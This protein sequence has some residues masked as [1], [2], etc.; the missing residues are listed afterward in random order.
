MPINIPADLPARVAL[1]RENIF[2][3]SDDKAVCQ[4]IRPMRLAIVNLMPTKLTTEIQLLRLLGNTPLQID[5]ILLRAENHVSRHT[6]HEHLDKFYTTFSQV[7]D[8]KFDGMIIT[9]APVELLPFEE[10]DYW[11]EL[12]T[13]MDY[14]AENVFSTMYICWGAQAGLY[15]RYGIPKYPLAE[16]KFGVFDHTLLQ[17]GKTLFRGFDDVFRVPHSRHTEV[18]REDIENVPALELLATSE[19][20][21]VGVVQAHGTGEIFVTGHFEYEADT[22]SQEYFRDKNKNLPIK[23]PA[24]YFPGD[25]PALP[26][27]NI[28]RSHAHLFFSNW[29]NYHVYQETPYDLGAIKGVRHG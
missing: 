18:R 11:E 4:D 26:P 7:K 10:V 8:R 12:T 20:A 22:L 13:I 16:K 15:H 5:I 17:P 21:G 28:W 3:M 29:L 25:N 9:G 14:S 24:H 2:V 1:E 23:R 6:S 27:L 19:E